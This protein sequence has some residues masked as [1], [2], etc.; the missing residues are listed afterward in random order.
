MIERFG[1]GSR[2]VRYGFESLVGKYQYDLVR[3]NWTRKNNTDKVFMLYLS[4]N[5]F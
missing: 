3:E 2:I 4:M 1:L 5:E